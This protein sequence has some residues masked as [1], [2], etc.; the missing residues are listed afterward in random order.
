MSNYSITISV[1]MMM[2]KLIKD[3]RKLDIIYNIQSS[4]FHVFNNEQK[5]LQESIRMEDRDREH[6]WRYLT[7]RWATQLGDVC[8]NFSTSKNLFVL[9]CNEQV[10]QAS[11]FNSIFI[12]NLSLSL[13]LSLSHTHTHTHT[14]F[15]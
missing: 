7:C 8:C 14:Q 1:M 9:H 2:M 11:H 3:P 15:T 13:S 12:S 6:T 4:T 5:L 10:F